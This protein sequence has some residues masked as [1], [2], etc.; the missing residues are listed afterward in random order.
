MDNLKGPEL[1]FSIGQ[2]IKKI[3]ESKG[4]TRKDMANLLDITYSALANYENGNR[5]IPIF[6]ALD[7][8]KFL[9]VEFPFL[10]SQNDDYEKWLNNDSE[11]QIKQM[12]RLMEKLNH[13]GKKEAYKRVEELTL[14]PKYTDKDND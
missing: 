12:T 10:F 11:I 8:A 2:K 5:K 6:L 3:R 9:D 1:D 4:I 14:I 13:N 7:V